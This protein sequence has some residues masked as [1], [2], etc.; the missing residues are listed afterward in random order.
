MVQ[1]DNYSK[2]IRTDYRGVAFVLAASCV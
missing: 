1:N 2:S